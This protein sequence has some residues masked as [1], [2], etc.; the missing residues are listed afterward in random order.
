MAAAQAHV[1]IQSVPVLAIRGLASTTRHLIRWS[2]VPPDTDAASGATGS[3]TSLPTVED[4]QMPPDPDT[5][6]P[7]IP[8]M[9]RDMA[10][11]MSLLEAGVTVPGLAKVLITK[12]IRVS[13]AF[14]GVGLQAGRPPYTQTTASPTP[15]VA[16]IISAMLRSETA[17]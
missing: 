12:I 16:H 1:T 6:P 13:L 2:I 17:R 7:D 9:F 15:A 14:R 8:L 3:E 11:A 5:E 10:P 4:R